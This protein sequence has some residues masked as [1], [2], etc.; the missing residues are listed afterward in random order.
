[1]DKGRSSPSFSIELFTKLRI[2]IMTSPTRCD[3][4][5]RFSSRRNSIAACV[6][7]KSKSEQWSVRI[8]LCSSGISLL[9]ERNPA[10]M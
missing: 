7:A 3:F 6:G 1:M 10:S 8:R 5:P 4:D 2:S 9:F